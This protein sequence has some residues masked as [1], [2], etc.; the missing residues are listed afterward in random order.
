MLR[1]LGILVQLRTI[2]H[3]WEMKSSLQATWSTQRGPLFQLCK[4]A[5]CVR[6][7]LCAW[8]QSP[9]IRKSLKD[10]EHVFNL[11]LSPLSQY[12]LMTPSTKLFCCF[13]LYSPFLSYNLYL[14]SGI[15]FHLKHCKNLSSFSAG[16]IIF[17]FLF[18]FFKQHT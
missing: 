10:K 17:S 4:G 7:S 1:S 12:D 5:S 14:S 13:C 3:E 11:Y 15:Y 18:F 16:N 9:T 8:L 6:G 2:I